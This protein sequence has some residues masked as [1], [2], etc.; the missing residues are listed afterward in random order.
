MADLDSPAW[1]A[2]VRAMCKLC[3]AN[4]DDLFYRLALPGWEAELHSIQRA[5]AR[6]GG[7][8]EGSGDGVS[9]TPSATRPH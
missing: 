9:S 4:Q 7:A 8:P 6:S 5:D 1:L 2:H 3:E